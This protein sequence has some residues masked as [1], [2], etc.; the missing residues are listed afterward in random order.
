MKYGLAALGVALLWGGTALAQPGQP[1]LIGVGETVQ[2]E[3]RAG[4]DTGEDDSFYDAFVFEGRAGQRVAISL[5]SKAFDAYLVLYRGDEEMKTD[6]DGG[7]GPNARIN[8]TL[9]AAGRYIILANAV[10]KGETGPYALKLEQTAAQAPVVAKPGRI[11]IGAAVNGRLA[12]GDALADDDTLYDRYRFRG[13]T[14]DRVTVKL[15]SDDFDTYVA[16]HRAD[17][18]EEL[19]TNDDGEESG[20]D[21][22]LTFTLPATGEYD[23][24]ANSLARDKVG[25]YRLSLARAAPRAP[26]GRFSAK[27][28]AIRYDRPTKGDLAQGDAQAGDDSYYDLY[29]FRGRAGEQ[30]TITMTSPT[31]DTYLSIH[32][33]DEIKELLTNDDGPHGSDSQIV[34]VLPVAGEYDIWANSV[35]RGE[36]GA[37]SLHL[38]RGAAPAPPAK[39]RPARQTRPTGVIA[40]GPAP[41]SELAAIDVTHRA[42]RLAMDGGE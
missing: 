4:D 21:S 13:R 37:Y 3:L 1:R 32:R 36:S 42:G 15:A 33:K 25:D 22:E 5:E 28:Q 17:A 27:V 19:A 16:I 6:D 26:G 10:N 24:W 29:R 41:R 35:G 39:P 20:S 30:V 18:S 31:F 9:P 14:G 23:I 34:Y 11:R 7:D 8:F 12:P 40:A 38:T 2:G